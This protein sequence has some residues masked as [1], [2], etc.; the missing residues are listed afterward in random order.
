MDYSTVIHVVLLVPWR[1]VWQ[2]HC[3]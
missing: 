3:P 1:I 2:S